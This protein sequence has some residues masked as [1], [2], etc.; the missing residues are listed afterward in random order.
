M[1]TTQV[2]TMCIVLWHFLCA[3]A[4]CIVLQCFSLCHSIF[5]L[6]AATFLL[7]KQEKKKILCMA[8]EAM[9]AIAMSCTGGITSRRDGFILLPQGH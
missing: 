4:L 5:L 7:P 6:A 8:A 3:A 2:A 9:L 1:F